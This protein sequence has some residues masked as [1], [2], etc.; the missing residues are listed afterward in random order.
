MSVGYHNSDQQCWAIDELGG[1]A[2]SETLSRNVRVVSQPLMKFRQLTRP[3]MAF[4]SHQGSKVTFRKMSNL[5]D[6]G[7][8]IGEKEKTP[9]TT[10]SLSYGEVTVQEWTNSVDYTWTLS[11]LAKLS[12]EDM[13]IIGLMNDMAKTLDE[14]A[15]TPFRDADL[16]YTPT[17]TVNNKTRTLTTN[18]TAGAVSTRPFSMWD[19]KNV[20]DDFRCVYNVPAYDNNDYVCVTTCTGTRGIKDDPEWFAA[21]QYGDP[22][23]LFSGEVGRIY[24][25]R[26]IEENNVLNANLPNGLG[27]MIFIGFDAVI[28]IVAYAEEI[29]AKIGMDYG[30]DK[31]IRWVWVGGFAKVWDFA[32]EGETRLLKVYSA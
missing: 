25:V 8:T 10:F 23:R 26:F 3:E 11:L 9:N 15:S 31:G 7:R 12:I 20:V 14:A 30:R 4:G 19:L 22:E 6:R 24:G 18:G 16:V 32:A 2:T 21:A 27:E 17:G 1:M 28:E 29:Q 5:R 13:I